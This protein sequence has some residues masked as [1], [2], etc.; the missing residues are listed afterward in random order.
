MVTCTVEHDGR[1]SP[2][3]QSYLQRASRGATGVLARL[4]DALV[5]TP[6]WWIERREHETALTGQLMSHAFVEPAPAGRE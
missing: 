1:L 2:G 5:W 3:W 6:E 4:V